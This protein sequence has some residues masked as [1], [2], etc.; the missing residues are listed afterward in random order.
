MIKTNVSASDS[1][2]PLIN[3]LIEGRLRQRR[4]VGR[5]KLLLRA[6]AVAAFLA[7]TA[8]QAQPLGNLLDCSCLS[9]Q[10]VLFTNACCGVIPDLCPGAANCYNPSILPAPGFTCVQTPAPGTVVCNTT[11]ITFTLIENVFFKSNTCVLPFYV[12]LSTS[13]FT[14]LCPP[15]QIVPC[16]TTNWVFG[17]IGWTNECCSTNP[18][19]AVASVVTNWPSITT[20]WLLTDG[21]GNIDSCSQSITFLDPFGLPCNCLA[22]SCPSNIVIQTC[23]SPFSGTGTTNVSYPLPFVTNYCIGTISSIVFTPPSGSPFPVGTNTVSCTVYDTLSNSATCTFDVVVLG[24]TTPPVITCFGPQTYQCG[25]AWTPVRPTAI[26]ACCG[27]NVN[28][29]LLSAVTNNTGPCQQVI[30]F[31]WDAQDCNGNHA[32]CTDVVTIVDTIPPVIT[33]NSNQFYQCGAAGTPGGW[34]LVPPTAFDACSGSNV[35]VSLFNAVTNTGFPC[36]GTVMLTWQATDLCTNSAFC[37]EIV[38]LIDTNPPTIIC[39]SNK[40]VECGTGWTFDTPTA[41]DTC[42]GTNVTLTVLSN[43]TVFASTCLN[44]YD[45]FW[46]ATDC[47]TNRAFCNQRVTEVDTHPPVMTCASNLTV[48]CGSPWSFTPPTAVDA[49]CGTNVTITVLSTLTNSGTLCPVVITRTWQA[50]D[51]CTNSATC[52]QTV[53][54][55]DTTPPVITCGPNQTV[56]CGTAWALNPPTAFDACCTTNV[57]VGLLSTTT[58]TFLPCQDRVT[59]IWRA[60]DCCGNTSFCTNFV[61]IEDTIPPV[62]TCRSNYVVQCGSPILP[63]PATDNCCSNPTVTMLTVVT[64]AGGACNYTLNI[65]WQAQDC[66]TNTATCAEVVRIIDTTPPVITCA[67]NKTVAC[68]TAWSFDP[69]T[70]V[71]ACCG[72][73]VTVTTLSTVTNVSSICPVIITRTWQATDCCTNSATCSQVVTIV[74]TTPPVITCA[75]S[76]TTNFGSAW[77]FTPPTAFDAC[78]GT[79]VT[80][81]VLSTVTNGTC[82]Q[83]ITRTWRATDCCNNAAVCNQVVTVLGGPGPINDLCANAIT[84]FAG[85][86]AYSCGTTIC[87]TPSTNIPPVCGASANSPDVWFAYTPICSGPLTINTCGACPGQPTFDTV[88]SAY[89]GPCNALTMIACND[90]TG[91]ACGLQ[92]TIN[93]VGTAGVTYYLRVSGFLGASGRFQLNIIGPTGPPPNDLCVNAQVVQVGSPAAC[94]NTMCAT[95]SAPFSIPVPCGNSM[96]SRDVWYKWTP[97]CSGLATID[98]CG[99]CPGQ[100]TTFNTVLSVYTG[101][102]GSLWP[103]ACNDDN[104][105]FGGCSPQ[106]KVSFMA[107]AGITYTIRV[108]GFDTTPAGPFRLNIAQSITPPFN[109]PCANAITLNSGGVSMFSTCGATT[110]GPTQPGCQPNSDVWFKYIA[111]CAGQVSVNVCLANFDTVVSVYTGP[112]GGLSLVACNDNAASGPCTG[113]PGSFLTFNATAGT[114]YTIRIGGVGAAQGWGVIQVQGPFPAANTC[115][116]A[117]GPCY[118]R[119][120]QVLGTANNTPWSWSIRE[121]C[122]ANV[123]VTSVPG[124][125]TGSTPNQ[126]AQAFCN[127]INAACGGGGI[128]AVPFPFFGWQGLFFVC[129]KSC[130]ATPTPFTFS[131]GPAGTPAVNQCIVGNLY[132]GVWPPLPLPTSGLCSFNPELVELPYANT[133]LNNNGVD[134]ALDIMSGTSADLNMNGIPDEAETCQVPQILTQPDS[135]QV[136]PLGTN[137]T[138]AVTATGTA[139][140]SYQWSHNGAPLAGYTFTELTLTNVTAGQM[141]DYGLIVA[142]ACGTNTVGPIT[143]IADTPAAPVEPMITSMTLVNGTFQLT[144]ATK[145]GQTYNVEYKNHLSDNSWTPLTTVSGDGTEHTVQDTPPLPATRFYRIRMTIP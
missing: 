1:R 66:C 101:L 106:S 103:V 111:P 37:T 41:F 143:L 92:S 74:D 39:S 75:P 97:T 129:V 4:L 114:T 22:I 86:P 55:V 137:L 141:G 87:A 81:I 57:T 12:G 84:V 118:W 132:T 65:T 88:L 94:G 77:S 16:G 11:N 119:A 60:R 68:G 49:C 115:P 71:D 24:D 45:R 142:N 5:I 91:G 3:R 109:D 73:N 35:I 40:T 8:V 99:M 34:V 83:I 13:V 70:A 130:T 80:V 2:N 28:I 102:C 54:I 62:I 139:P 105:V 19:T 140:L 10:A 82:P 18:V 26:D 7:T 50:T 144:F 95:P 110:D 20:T 107:T 51:C 61:I 124:L 120:F 145:V 43:V 44:I 48:N 15:S 25:S 14:A 76:F 90:D 126:L 108:A 123:T 9:T 36:N 96:N 72:T 78:C 38:T 79:N 89:T 64:N 128:Q 125:P 30:L 98:T 104:N 27:T 138:L 31:K 135:P 136:V 52:A 32:L 121:A 46:M 47:C 112:C 29:T 69:V 117:G 42:C 93:F 63:P 53:T 127:S 23:L 133:D 116:P 113:G 131:I 67:T 33:C 17:P 56:Q 58:N 6:A 100:F 122:C 21:C 85:T 59:A 134:D